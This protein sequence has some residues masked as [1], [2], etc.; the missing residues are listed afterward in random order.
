[1]AKVFST[2]DGNL[3]NSIR[4]VRERRYS[5]IDLTLNARTTGSNADGDVFRKIDAAAVKQAVKNIL[6]TNAFERPYQPTFGANL[7]S[8]LFELQDELTSDLMIDRIKRSIDKYEPRAQV[9]RI[10]VLG[11]LDNNSVYVSVEFRVI[12][13]PIVDTIKVE[14]TSVGAKL[15]KVLPIVAPELPDKILKTQT[16][17]RLMTF[18][19]ILIRIDEGEEPPFTIL[20]Q[21]GVDFLLTQSDPPI[22]RQAAPD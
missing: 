15:D 3:K 1:M 20:T 13:T 17:D 2:E 8:L 14:I 18:G 21:D 6:L 22:L 4:I 5:D 7:G 11:S 10:Q 16:G 9:G 12:S 19:D